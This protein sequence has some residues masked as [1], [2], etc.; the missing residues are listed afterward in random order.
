[1]RPNPH[2]LTASLIVATLISIVSAPVW[3]NDG[4]AEVR[5]V[6]EAFY[7]AFNDGFT[8]PADYAAE[9]WNHINPLGGRTRSREETLKEVR[10]VHQSF[11][12]GATDTIESMDIRFATPDVAVGTVVSLGSGFTSPDGVKH[13]RPRSI[14]TFVMVRRDKHWQIMQDQNTF[15]VDT[16]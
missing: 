3:A 6:I 5:S 10:E 1:M 8:Q 12:K 13:T 15:I 4:E 14:R 16:H 11:L 7:K 2:S 9:D